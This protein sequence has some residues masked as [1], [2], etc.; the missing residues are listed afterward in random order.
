M[1]IFKTNMFYNMFSSKKHVS[2][3]REMKIEY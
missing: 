2:L 1:Q 3:Q